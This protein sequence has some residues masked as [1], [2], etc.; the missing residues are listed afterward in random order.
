MDSGKK[1]ENLRSKA[2]EALLKKKGP[3]KKL[4]LEI[5]ELIHELEVYQIELEMQNEDLIKTQNELEDSKRDYYELYDFAPVGYFTLDENGIIQRVN[6]TGCDIFGI[7]RN[8]L[9]RRAFIIFIPTSSRKSFHDHLQESRKSHA[10]KQC[11][12]ELKPRDKTP[13]FVSLD[14]QA[15]LND[16]GTFKEFRII[17]TDINQLK[18]TE[19]ALHESGKKYKNLADLLP[20]MVVEL[21]KNCEFTFANRAVFELT[22]YT[23]EDLD[24][25]K[26]YQLVI[27]EDQIRVKENI[28][29]I[30][31]GEEIGGIE[32]TAQRK[33]GGKFPIVVYCSK[34]ITDNALVGFRAIILDYT[35][36]KEAKDKVQ[37]SLEEK[38]IL[39]KEIHHRVKN[40]LVIISSLLNLQS[41]YIKD[42]SSRDMFLESQRRAKSMAI[43]HERMYQS[44]DLKRIDFGDYIRTLC[45]DLY[46]TYVSNPE[47]IKLHMDLEPVKV[48]INTAIPCGL[49]LN[50]LVSN[51]MKHAFPDDREGELNIKFYS[52]G[53]NLILSVL[54]NGVGFPNDIDF[55][56]I[57]SLGL[58]I[59][60]SLVEQI[61]GEI[62]MIRDGGTEFTITFPEGKLD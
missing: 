5:N 52:I 8:Q 19:I 32:Y 41:N 21:N 20:Q 7:P 9:V 53:K 39:L 40:N 62:E 34:I 6:L 42:K 28:L 22:G 16:N 2:E 30:M 38:E 54:D 13:I 24:G 47:K 56:K 46:R 23:R 55:K 10:K 15:V 61:D 51:A 35:E 48:D 36:L 59:V 33:D 43:I 37:K 49:I 12:I 27:P 58:N 1:F 50:E 26:L 11:I 3:T 44:T 31:N 25:F 57:D 4:A 18:K 60:N 45:M 14:T 17:I 29:Q